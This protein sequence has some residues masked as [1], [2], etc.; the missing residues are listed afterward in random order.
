MNP[1]YWVRHPLQTALSMLPIPLGALWLLVAPRL[2]W[3]RT[4]SGRALLSWLTWLATR[5]A[6][7]YLFWAL[8]HA[9]NS[10]TL[11]AFVPEAR[12]A[13]AGLI[14]YRDFEN[15]YG[16]LFPYLLILPVRLAG[17]LGPGLLFLLADLLAWRLVAARG[18]GPSTSLLRDPAWL[19]LNFTPVWYFTV[20]YAQDEVLSAFFLAWGLLLYRARRPLATG[21]VMAAGVLVAKPLFGLTGLPFLEQGPGRR[22]RA[23]LALLMPLVAVYGALLVL[24]APFWRLLFVQTGRFGVGHTLWRAVM[25]LGGVTLPGWAWVPF[26][27]VWIAGLLWIALRRAGSVAAAVWTYGSYALLSPLFMPMYVVM[28]APALAVWAAARARRAAWL[29]VAGV[30]LPLSFYVD[31]GPIQGLFGPGWQAVAK[32]LLCLSVLASVW[33]LE[34]TAQGAASGPPRT[35]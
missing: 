9:R 14:P 32:I 34:E 31:S 10:D 1:E 18:R 33:L 21:F 7:A 15:I 20:R 2:P 22:R 11:Y 28:W 16:P 6:F 29:A 17:T 12:Q 25:I 19:Y 23:M 4:G 27:V 3:A 13:A 8:L 24:H 35:P 30:L 26:A 5:A